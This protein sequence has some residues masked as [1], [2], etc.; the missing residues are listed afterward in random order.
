MEVAGPLGTPLG[1]AQ[2]AGVG[3]G[4]PVVLSEVD[5]E[6]ENSPGAHPGLGRDL[7]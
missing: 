3:A 4:F 1:L 2:R 5:T 6:A 7:T